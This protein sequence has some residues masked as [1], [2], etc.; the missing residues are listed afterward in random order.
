MRNEILIAAVAL[1]ASVPAFSQNLNPQVQVTN[2]YKAE[3]GKAVKQSVPLEIPDSLNSFRTSVSYN[4]FATPYTGSYE[5][6]PYEISVTPQKP[7]SDYNKFYLK[8]GAGY[9]LR[10]ELKAVW[11][12][13]RSVSGNT[14]TVF[15]DLNGY[16]GNYGTLDSRN[17]YTGYDISETF[18]LEGRWFADDFALAYG[19]DYKGLF[20]ND[21][22]LR[23]AFNDFTL[24]AAL[25]SDTDSK[26]LYD[27]NLAV[28]QAFDSIVTQTGVK[29]AGGFLPNWMLPFDLRLDFNLE[30]DIY[31]GDIYDNTFVAQ[32]AA[33]ALF[34]WYPVKLAAGVSFSPA[35][36]IQWL[37]PDVE[38][39][40]D[41][42]DKVLQL[43]AS[44]KGGQF[45]QSYTDLKLENH[46]FNSSY[47]AKIKPTFER[48]NAS[49]GLR[50]S[51]FKYMQYDVHGG[52]ASY[53]DAP[54][55][56][57]TS[58]V[59]NPPVL[60]CGI[61]YA[62]YNALYADADIHWK[63]PRL[64]IDLNIGFKHTNVDLNDN[65]LDLPL[66]AG[67]V[68]AM[69]NWN[70]RIFAGITCKGHT[71][72][73]ALTWNVPGFADLALT[74]EYKFNRRFGVWANLGN[75]LCQKI[76]YSPLHVQK[77]IYFTGGITL[78]LR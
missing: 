29:A 33:K 65:Y 15:Q 49:L 78:D 51:A 55:H 1:L 76:A 11:T 59:Y 74:G 22:A 72:Q 23:T 24:R 19:L 39:T 9:P 38:F 61:T 37:Y 43:Y 6:T 10:P 71:V 31:G 52:W 27:L 3:M 34:E 42:M 21:F 64:A 56:T 44:V 54:M 77:G 16:T 68:S 66:L 50:G 5:F 2:D 75:L 47:V 7:S 30:T 62:D 12:P 32:I 17:S 67:A 36:D 57:L 60:D 45:V 40:A 8:A 48:I 14:L 20:N 73:D 26:I 18:G 13:L 28:S 63:S 53:S 25:R 4:V 46:W 58:S 70:S 69:Y 41:L 35:S